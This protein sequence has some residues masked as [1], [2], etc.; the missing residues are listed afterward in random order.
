MTVN[1]DEQISAKEN[2]KVKLIE[3]MELIKDEYLK[4]IEK[5]S[6]DWIQTTTKREVT[7]N[8]DLA[9]DIGKEKLGELKRKVES[10]IEKLPTLVN[11][12]LNKN[13]LWW[14]KKEDKAWYSQLENRILSKI[15]REV[16]FMYGEL[17][18]I[19]SEYGFVRV[20]PKGFKD[21]G[22][23]AEKNGYGM[24]GK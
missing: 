4:E 8:P 1:Y 13:E 20:E 14:H 11:Q 5:F 19:L 16:Q 24:Y 18:I 22:I 3:K 12:Y 2:E 6:R 7:G 23:W 15:E 9:L 10:L 21:Y 17:G